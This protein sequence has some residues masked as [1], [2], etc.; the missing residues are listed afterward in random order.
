MTVQTQSCGATFPCAGCSSMGWDCCVWTW[1][2]AFP[3]F[4]FS[5]PYSGVWQDGQ[6]PTWKP[7]PPPL[8]SG[9]CHTPA[10]WSF[11]LLLHASC[12]FRIPWSPLLKFASLFCT[13]WRSRH[14]TPLP[15]GL[16]SPNLGSFQF[17][18]SREQN[19]QCLV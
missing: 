16:M 13:S 17:R 10:F 1:M 3:H 14:L 11:L 8:P 7:P 5:A 6:G 19:P 18:V 9:G 2:A 15:T 12:S 4:S